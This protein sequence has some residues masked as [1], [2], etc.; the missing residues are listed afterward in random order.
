MFRQ[1][2]E[3]PGAMGRFLGFWSVFIQAA[4]SFLGTETVALAAAE[5]ENPKRTVPRAI[6][7]VFSRVLLFYV[8]SAFIIGIVV[9]FNDP[10]LL[11]GTGDASSSPFVIAINRAKIKVLPDLIN[12]VVLVSAYSATSS[13][14]CQSFY[15]TRFVPSAVSLALS[16]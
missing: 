2:N 13:E 8:A 12:A 16:G 9:P 15:T 11:G 7:G 4:Y 5:T 3:I 10:H 6:K 14:V 1:L